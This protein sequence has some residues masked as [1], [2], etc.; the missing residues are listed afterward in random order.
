MKN[1]LL[2]GAFGCLLSCAAFA[3]PPPL[4]P[5]ERTDT[6]GFV[7]ITIPLA[8][9]PQPRLQIGVQRATVGSNG[10]VTGGAVAFSFDPWN[11]G[12]IQLHATAMKGD[13]DAAGILGGGWDFGTGKPFGT[14]GFRVPLLSFTADI[15][16]GGVPS[17]ALGLDSLTR[18]EAPDPVFTC[19]TFGPTYFVETLC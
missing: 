12:G 1:S 2:P 7:G 5:T 4:S 15:G 6:T 11:S 19:P 14:L 16:A 3:A 17:F 8:A 9:N 18:M 10:D 13:V